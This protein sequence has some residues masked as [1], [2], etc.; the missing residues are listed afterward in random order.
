MNPG[1]DQPPLA[2]GLV[3][4]KPVKADVPGNL[5]RIRETVAEAGKDVDL[6]VFPE[7]AVSGYFL[8]GGVAEAAL[9]AQ[10]LAEGMG[11]SGEGGS[12][13]VVGFYE[14]WRRR[15][16]NSVAW[17]TPRDGGWYTVHVH[18]KMFLPTYGLFQEARFVEAGT[19]LAAFDTR[20]GRVGMLI[21]EELWHSLVPTVLALDGAELL[22]CV[23]ASPARDFR[24]GTGQPGIV[25]RWADLARGVAQEHGVFVALCQLVGSEGGKIFPGCS[26]VMGPDGT[27]LARGPFLEEGVTT[28]ALEGTHLDRA[29]GGSPLL[30][31]LEQMLPHLQAAL[32]RTVGA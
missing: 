4:F 19:Q 12:D 3:Q 29:R 18:R 15:L 9:T 5:A 17:L 7:G 20:L 31:D 22:V 1:N 25:S 11:P 21:C 26:L 16:Y 13:I 10:Q 8:E 28:V 2:M 14:R 32:G 6:L 30:A 27:E 23:S 24:P